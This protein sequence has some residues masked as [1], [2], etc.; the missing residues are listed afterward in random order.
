V[1]LLLPSAA[2][3]VLHWAIFRNAHDIFFYLLMDIA[4]LFVQ[5]VLG[6]PGFRSAPQRAR[7]SN[8]RRKLNVAMGVF[9]NQVGT[10]LLRL[11][12]AF[13]GRAEARVNT[14]GST[15]LGPRRTSQ[16]CKPCCGATNQRSTQA[17][18][19]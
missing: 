10:P 9:F 11:L 6:H 18:A 2:A 4:F 16:K 19:I 14:S 8:I 3:Y 1:L 5:A 12:S 17:G 15:V 7:A 13:D